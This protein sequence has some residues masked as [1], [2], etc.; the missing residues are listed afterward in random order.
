[1][2][3]NVDVYDDLY[4][5]ATT[6]KF[7]IEPMRTKILLVIDRTTH[8]IYTQ[9]A[10]PSQIPQTASRRKIWGIV[11]IVRLLSCPYLIVID[12]AE[13]VGTVANQNIFK[14]LATHII[15]YTRSMLHLDEKQIRNNEFYLEMVKSILN[16]PHFYFSYTYDLSHTMQRLHNTPPEFIQMPLH[17]RADPRFIWNSYLLQ[18]LVAR[19]EHHK[20]CLPIIHGF[21]SL[22]TVVVNGISFNWG[23]ISRRSVHRA[24]TRLFSRG[25]DANGNVSNF[26]ETEQIVE[27]NGSKSSFVQTR[28]SIPLFW[29]QTPNLKYKPKPVLASNE[30]HLIA[31]ARHFESQIFHYGKQ[32]LINLIDHKGAEATLEKA[33]RDIVQ[34]LKNQNI[35]Y[36]AFDFHAECGKMQWH[37]LEIL[38]A[39]LA[40][41][42]EQMGYFLLTRDNVL[43]SVQDGIFRTNCI[44]CLDRTN[45]VQSMLAKRVLTDTLSKLEISRNM[46]EHPSLEY[47]FKQVWADNADIISIQYSGTSALKTDF[48]RTGKRT[49]MG[50]IKDGVNS[51]TRYYKNNF[52][53]GFRQDAISL[54]LGRYIVQD[55]ECLTVTCPL[56]SERNWRYVTFPLVLLVASV[57]FVAH[58]ILPSKYSTETLLYMLFWA[59]MVA[60][61]FATI[62]HHGKQ[63]VNKPK[64]S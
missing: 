11:G 23:I 21:L 9:A 58:I 59:A 55:G 20:F 41:D 16:T 57:M 7:Y 47:L 31:C 24:G 36:E 49:K 25:I 37:R 39:R 28:G 12:D 42:Q 1:M 19:P 35:K 43:L 54:F 51:L 29:Q 2:A 34:E 45:V 33:Y 64:L 46:A 48:T 4:L 40:H 3:T 32:I 60:G 62:I 61:T 22:N 15:P 8:Q 17:D 18:D 44:D 27:A 10:N 56:E 52:T 53:D 14:I 30:S 26:V 63:Y 5:Y 13:K 50:A 38:M 6:D